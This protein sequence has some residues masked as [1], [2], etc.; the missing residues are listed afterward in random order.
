[1]A[2]LASR[3]RAEMRNMELLFDIGW[4]VRRGTSCV[5]A[6]LMA[7]V[8]V[9]LQSVNGI[10]AVAHLERERHPKQVPSTSKTEVASKKS[11][12]RSSSFDPACAAAFGRAVRAERLAREIAQDQFAL[13][14]N[15]DRSYYGKLE[16]GERQPSLGI[17]FRVAKAFD[18][19]AS[20]LID[21]V[22][23]ELGGSSGG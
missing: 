6:P 5:A 11:L 20:E 17:I 22:E 14:A 15:I 16:R 18:L 21:R 7:S 3:M 2:R 1:M 12:G 13:L 8:F 9:L 19:P 4:F 10:Y 23:A